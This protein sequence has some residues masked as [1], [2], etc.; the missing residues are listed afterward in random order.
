[1]NKTV[2]NIKM[3][4]VYKRKRQTVI[5]S[6]KSALIETYNIAREQRLARHLYMF[7]IWNTQYLTWDHGLLPI[8]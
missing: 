3:L 8:G 4:T 1:M 2:C 6:G 7:I 5:M